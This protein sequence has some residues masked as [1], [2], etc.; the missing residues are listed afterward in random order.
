MPSSATASSPNTSPKKARATG[1]I[2]IAPSGKYVVRFFTHR[3]ETTNKRQ[4]L[5]GTADSKAAAKALLRKFNEMRI[6]GITANTKHTLGSWLTE[7]FREH[8]KNDVR[9]RTLRGYQELLGFYLPDLLR[10][11][12]LGKLT[13]EGLRRWLVDLASNPRTEGKSRGKVISRSTLRQVHSIMNKAL[14][15]ATERGHLAMNPMPAL[16]GQKASA[17]LATADSVK[18]DVIKGKG[19]KAIRALTAEQVGRFLEV[20]DARTAKIESPTRKVVERDALGSFWW[21]L[22]ETGMRP[23]ELFGLTWEH[24]HIDVANGEAPTV[25]VV[26]SLTW[27]EVTGKEPW[28]TLE[29]VKTGTKGERTLDLQSEAVD[30]LRKQRQRQAADKLV[31]GGDYAQQGF[32]FADGT[33]QPLRERFVLRSIF[34]PLLK[35]AGLPAHRLYDLR[36]TSATLLLANGVPVH[37][38]SQRLGHRD[39]A[40]TLDNYAH[41][42]PTQQAHASETI[43]AVMRAALRGAVVPLEA[44]KVLA[45]GGKTPLK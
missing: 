11:H 27:H 21:L 8:L 34:R 3:D 18:S 39:I 10:V 14:R 36:H 13:S 7:Y 31:M 38:V 26:Q 40:T 30:A 28:W 17:P 45:T 22:I 37:V 43:A 33:G 1:S 2:T 4:Y 6:A 32:V 29:R 25:D 41:V 23:G 44:G 24:V 12:P 15:T 19:R 35:K 16:P 9:E 5:N 20:A 42:L